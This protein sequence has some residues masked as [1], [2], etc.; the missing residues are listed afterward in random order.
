MP[1][2][3]YSSRKVVAVLKPIK[4]SSENFSNLAFK[5]PGHGYCRSY[6]GQ[7]W[8]YLIS[9]IVLALIYFSWSSGKPRNE[10]HASNYMKLFVCGGADLVPIPRSY[11]GVAPVSALRD[12]SWWC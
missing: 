2:V 3:G 5:L 8:N 11:S 4:I 1:W 6:V 9:F 10:Y 12:Q 7:Q